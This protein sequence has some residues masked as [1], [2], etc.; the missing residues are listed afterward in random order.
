MTGRAIETN[1][2]DNALWARYLAHRDVASREAV[3]LRYVPLVHF[4]L[5]R[6]G[7]T[8]ASGADYEDLASQGLL[9]LIDAVDRY[10]P[11]FGTQFST[12]A[13]LRIRGHILDQLRSSDWLSRAARRR[14]REV[15]NAMT[16]LWGQL[17]RA[18]TDEELAAYLNLDLPQLRQALME[19]GR[20]IVSLDA[21]NGDRREDD[22]PLHEILTDTDNADN[23]DPGESLMEKELRGQLAEA[24]KTLPER[25][26]LVMS[27]YYVEEL[28]LKE[29]GAVL[30]LS[31]SR[32]CQLHARALTQLRAVLAEANAELPSLS[33]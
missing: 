15:Q 5:N 8:P 9:G 19:A 32:I 33:A 24:L 23:A 6:L 18:P 26:Q 4:V 1:D 31:E 2:E 30:D 29:I 13:T 21:A 3:I 10:D 16:V 14:A 11:Q 22:A 27:L 7:I 17:H 28:T 20:V 25:E 12:Y